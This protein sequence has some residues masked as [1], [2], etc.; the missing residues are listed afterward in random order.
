[1]KKIILI[2]IFSLLGFHI[3]FGENNTDDKKKEKRRYPVSFQDYVYDLRNGT[4]EQ[5][6]NAADTLGKWG[7][8]NAVK[9]LINC[10]NDPDTSVKISIV[11]AL[12]TAEDKYAL[13]AL[14]ETLKKVDD[15]NLR[16]RIT[17]AI[18]SISD[19]TEIPLI[20][21]YA[22]NKNEN[23]RLA[24]VEVLSI[25]GDKRAVPILIENLQNKKLIFRHYIFERLEVLKDKRAVPALLKC[26]EDNDM[27]G[28]ATRAIFAI[29]D[30]KV[31]SILVD[32]LINI[33]IN[34]NA[35][36]RAYVLDLLPQVLG[37]N[38]IEKILPLLKDNDYDVRNAAI[39][40][41]SRTRDRNIVPYLIRILLQD[42]KV[43]II[44]T[45][46][47]ALAI[48][49]DKRAVPALIRCLNWSPS[50]IPESVSYALEE[51][52]DAKAIKP[53]FKA[54]R[55]TNDLNLKTKFIEAL[56]KLNG[57]DKKVLILK[58]RWDD[59]EYDKHVE[60]FFTVKHVTIKRENIIKFINDSINEL[61]YK[62]I[63]QIM[64]NGL[65]SSD[66][67]IQMFCIKKLF[68][69]R[70]NKQTFKI[71]LDNINN[72]S[73]KVRLFII[74]L[75]EF[76]LDEKDLVGV[77]APMLKQET[78]NDMILGI[79][80]KIEYYKVERNNTSKRI[81]PILKKFAQ[82]NNSQIRY[83]ACKCL[84]NFGDSLG[85]EILFK[86]YRKSKNIAL[87]HQL[88]EMGDERIIS[89]AIVYLKSAKKHNLYYVLSSLSCFTKHNEIVPHLI[90]RLRNGDEDARHIVEV[91]GKFND[92]RVVP[93]LISAVA[94]TDELAHEQIAIVLGNYSNKK[95][96]PILI[97]ILND[98]W[99]AGRREAAKALGK[100]KAEE[101]LSKLEKVADYDDADHV[102]LSAREAIIFIKNKNEIKK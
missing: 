85:L 76:P 98:D 40:V 25:K 66:E 55:N 61:E 65:K 6:R 9:E 41:L 32:T 93:A 50:D 7:N 59:I 5:K 3:V 90:K 82:N 74:G 34:P 100:L 48:F 49:K 12:Q 52:G 23:I 63:F 53:L 70:K 81:I 62:D 24:A 45:A 96:I 19:K 92:E 67:E 91:L 46:A 33:V 27:G 10:L 99:S 18:I 78:N 16:R 37:K 2:L 71:I 97:K 21:D 15:Y 38:L 30:P 94:Y 26:I 75:L 31:T 13:T 14:F 101:S 47:K 72:K 8:K 60:N 1:M 95:S 56:V 87:M 88:A 4:I 54:L 11:G 84:Y 35:E 17:E 42:D 57:I 89:D 69:I 79:L 20:L 28:Y 73:L 86:E 77:L 29:G 83:S 39:E 44:C 80:G 43:G 51:I 102:R 22:K 36:N 58:P 64:E 68:Y